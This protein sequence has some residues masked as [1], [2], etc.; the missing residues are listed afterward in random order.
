MYV[1]VSYED[2]TKIKFARIHNVLVKYPIEI[3]L[4]LCQLLE[5]RAL[6]SS[7]PLRRA[8]ANYNL[9]FVYTEGISVR[10]DLAKAQELLAKAARLGLA[11]AQRAMI[12]F[13]VERP[14]NIQKEE[15]LQWLKNTAIDGLPM[16][17]KLLR[18]SEPSSYPTCKRLL[19]LKRLFRKSTDFL[20]DVEERD[21]SC[22]DNCLDWIKWEQSFLHFGAA[23]GLLRLV[24]FILHRRPDLLNKQDDMGQTPL[25]LT[26]QSGDAATVQYLIAQGVDCQRAD[27]DGVTP[28]HWATMLNGKGRKAIIYK[29]KEDGAH[30]D[31][32][33]KNAGIDGQIPRHL[34]GAPAINGTPLMWAVRLGD[35]DAVDALL[36]AGA[37]PTCRPVNQN[38][39]SPFEVACQL[40]ESQIVERFLSKREVVEYNAPAATCT[41]STFMSC[42]ATI[43]CSL[44]RLE[45]G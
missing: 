19:N 8:L 45:M 20:R 35:L 27:A 9:A 24:K 14:S 40:H 18:T 22:G 29:L 11:A 28:M 26:L 23:T 39:W 37:D 44:R 3:Q 32:W 13:C 7:E 33:A 10:I 25:A 17:L 6:D 36:E 34:L 2:L 1:H 41:W 43:L 12:S 42:P 15:W 16:S 4:Y 30:V 38:E 21:L 5:A 31:A